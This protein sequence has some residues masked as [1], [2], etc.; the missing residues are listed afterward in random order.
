MDFQSNIWKFYVYQFF[1]GFFLIESIGVLFY[2]LAGISY[3][4]LSTIEALAV[5]VV[6]LLEIPSGAFADLIGRKYSV[7]IGLFLSGIE[8]ILIAYGFTYIYFL[9]AVFIGGIGTSLISGADTALLYDSLKKLKKENEFNKILGKGKSVFFISVVI[10]AGIGSLIYVVNKPLVFYI[11]GLVFI[12][13][14]FFFLFMHEPGKREKF[15]LNKQLIHIKQSFSYILNHK[16]L[17]WIISFSVFSGAFISVFHNMLRQP[18]MKSIGIDIAAF[19]VLT[20]IL[21]L[22]RSLVAYKTSHIENSVGEKLS[23]YLVVLL[24]SFTFLAMAVVNIY[25]AF[26]FVVVIYCIW[27]YQ[28]IIMEGYTNRHMGS[29]QRATLISIHNFFRTFVLAVAFLLV[30]WLID[31]TSISF[32]L[33]LLAGLSLTAGLLLLSVRC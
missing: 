5:I 30:G 31:L 9:L 1:S 29:K 3:F 27:S 17:L 4:Q 19:G 7:F 22:A 20:S 16:R 25:I 12:I 28:E 10:A 15:S 8:F 18:Y 23:L 13:G 14:A 32:S 11:N 21:F 26:I 24:Q 2:L 6:L 33:Y